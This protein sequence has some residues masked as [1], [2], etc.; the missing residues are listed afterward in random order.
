MATS[1]EKLTVLT[2]TREAIGGK[3]YATRYV[4]GARP[5]LTETDE[6][7]AGTVA[8]AEETTRVEIHRTPNT[9]SHVVP[10]SH[11]M[12]RGQQWIVRY[13]QEDLG[14]T[15]YELSIERTQ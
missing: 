6:D 11:V 12:W 7:A 1:V 9:E 13:R 14:R 2:E 8:K 15:R 5:V 4:V 3:S 10:G